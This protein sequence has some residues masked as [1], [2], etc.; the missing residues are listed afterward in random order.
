[1]KRSHRK[2]ASGERQKSVKPLLE[3]L[4]ARI[5]LSDLT[6]KPAASGASIRQAAPSMT[7]TMPARLNGMIGGV[8]THRMT[9]IRG[10]ASAGAKVHLEIGKRSLV[11]RAGALG[12]YQFRLAMAPGT[13]ELKVRAQ[14]RSGSVTTA[15][16]STTRGDA[17]IAWINT[18]IDVIRADA[19]NVG[20]VSRTMAMVSAAVYDAVN[21]IER[22][23]AVFKVDV[24]APRWASR[25][26]A[27][28]EAAYTVLSS[29][30]PSMSP[31]LDAA[32]AQS[33][34]A[35]PA[36]PARN[37]GIAV[38]RKV[39]EGILQWR[40]DDGATDS[41]PYVPGTS[42]G[43]WR[44][45]PPDYTVAWGPDWGQVKP[46]AI[47]SPAAYAP[48]PP[49]ALGSPEYAAALN[50]VESLGALHS[51]TRTSDETQAANFWSYDAISTGT[52]P[53]RFEEIARQIALQE[54]NT[55]SQNA[56]LFGLVNIAMADSGITAWDAKYTYNFWRP[57]TAIHLANTDGNPAT[58]ADPTWTPLGSPGGP[59][60]PRFT[61]PFPGYVSGHAVFGAA[62]F[63]TLADFYGTDH[64]HFTIGSDELPGVT[65]SF[66]TFSAAALENAWSRVYLGVHFW[67]DEA[68]GLSMGA[69]VGNNIF[70]QIM[71]SAGRAT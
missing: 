3:S 52:P 19:G 37:A 45:T 67:F 58:V 13:Y 71:R 20:L 8:A 70:H 23:H 48:P 27:A 25:A 39:A 5:V 68:P 15:T 11:T 65:R 14:D 32:M 56:R 30:D 42:L 26:A 24:Q 69:A 34:A 40:T 1:M 38:G 46:F 35:V 53:V 47:A 10:H 12:N 22:T 36:G 41:V 57:V 51:T 64:M 66:D 6:G 61:P 16:M 55:L 31:R 28:S 4:E 50:Q 18:M 49:P 59:G 21:D 62:V 29:L 7:I 9:V 43:Q 17:V 33:L 63:T 54:H 2:R 60:Q 44:P